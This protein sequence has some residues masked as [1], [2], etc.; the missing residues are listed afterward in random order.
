VVRDANFEGAMKNCQVNLQGATN[1]AVPA[2]AN[3]CAARS[4]N[5][6]RNAVR[7]SPN[8]T[9]VEVLVARGPFGFGNT[10]PRSRAGGTPG[11]FW[12]AS[13]SRLYRVASRAIAI[14][15]AR[16]SASPSPLRS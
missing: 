12:S 13:L 10:D 11:R 16:A 1:E 5:V 15:A 3:C 7:Y 2:T 14:A 9:P 6:L 8:D 4:R